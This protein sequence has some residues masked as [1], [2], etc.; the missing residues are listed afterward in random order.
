LEWK[1]TKPQTLCSGCAREIAVGEGFYS[2]I[3]LTEQE[4]VRFDACDTCFTAEKHPDRIYW[5]TRRQEPPVKAKKVDYE[6][7]RDVFLKMI[8]KTGDS[9]GDMYRDLTYLMGLLLLRKRFYKLR[10]F[11][12]QD[13]RDVLVLTQPK[14]D[15]TI[16]LDAPLL[17]EARIALVREKL[18]QLLD[19]TI[20]WDGVNIAPTRAKEVGDTPAS[21]V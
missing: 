10:A 14:T 17:S 3:D 9:A 20:E 8:E 16:T 1:I 13:G 11:D 18:A 5:R 19:G 6:R 12:T 15:V 4:P 2:W 21:E 7:L